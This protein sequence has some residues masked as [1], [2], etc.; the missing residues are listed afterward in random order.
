MCKIYDSIE[1][2]TWQIVASKYVEYGT[3]KDERVLDA[4]EALIEVSAEGPEQVSFEKVAAR[5]F[6]AP[7]RLAG[8]Y[9]MHASF[10]GVTLPGK[11]T[12]PTALCRQCIQVID[13]KACKGHVC[14][15]LSDWVIGHAAS[16]Q[17]SSCVQ[18]GRVR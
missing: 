2:L 13:T 3:L 17:E 7:L 11:I 6:A 5:E 10:Y 15:M 8:S 14:S 1:A 9:V 12:L 16:A 4:G 18:G